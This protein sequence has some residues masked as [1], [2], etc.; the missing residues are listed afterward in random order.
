MTAIAVISSLM[1]SRGQNTHL[2]H[3]G[4]IRTAGVG[5]GKG[6]SMLAEEQS[7]Q[8]CPLQLAHLEVGLDD[9]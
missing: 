9:L 4:K 5:G 1:P 6:L 8:L 7:L 2:V 3:S